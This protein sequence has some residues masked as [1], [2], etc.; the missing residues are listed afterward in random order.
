MRR[1]LWICIGVLPSLSAAVAQ[2]SFGLFTHEHRYVSPQHGGDFEQVLQFGPWE[3]F[4]FERVW[5]DARGQLL[6]QEVGYL[7]SAKGVYV[8]VE[9]EEVVQKTQPGPWEQFE[10]IHLPDKKVGFRNL[11]FDR[12]LSFEGKLRTRPHLRH[13]ESFH[14]HWREGERRVSTGVFL[15]TGDIPQFPTAKHGGLWFVNNDPE[16]EY[17]A[18]REAHFAPKDFFFGGDGAI[19]TKMDLLH[20]TYTKLGD[21]DLSL[22]EAMVWTLEWAKTKRY[23]VATFNCWKLPMAF[24]KTFGLQEVKEPL[25]NDLL[26]LGAGAV[27]LPLYA[28]LTWR[29]KV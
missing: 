16:S 18:V 9:G 23:R 25:H 19:V 2:F 15:I 22:T 14:V 6:S 26:T 20:A 8:G 7:R 17:D 21:V 13:W 28:L 27:T 4:Q 5:V 24:A 11:A 3:Q 10:L 1:W 12:Y 29:K